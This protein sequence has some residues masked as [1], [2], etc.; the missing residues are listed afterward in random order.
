MGFLRPPDF[1]SGAS[2]C[3]ATVAYGASDR[4]RTDN[5]L[6][7]KQELCLLSYTGI[8]GRGRI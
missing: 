6:F 5:R 8:G 7:T 4:N 3:S 1:E 2:A